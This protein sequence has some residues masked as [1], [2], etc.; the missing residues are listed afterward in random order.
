VEIEK[1]PIGDGEKKKKGLRSDQKKG[2]KNK[3][4]ARK[5]KS[6]KGKIARKNRRAKKRK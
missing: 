6:A 5:G 3:T 4:G 1:C 2:R